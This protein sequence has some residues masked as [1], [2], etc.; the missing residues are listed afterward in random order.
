MAWHEWSFTPKVPVAVRQANARRA[1]AKLVESGQRLHP[2]QLEG[3]KI[4]TTSW[5]K[6][7]CGHLETYS[8]YANRLPRGRSYVRNGS[9]IDL[10]IEAGR[11]RAL[12]SGS[13]IYAVEVVIAQL[14]KARWETLV[15]ECSGKIDSVIE[16]LSGQLSETVMRVLCSPSQGL[17]PS[18]K[19]LALSCSCP[20]HA[21]LCKHLAAVLY[22]V[23]ARLD[24]EPELL[25][26]LR[27][28]EELDL[29]RD[30]ALGGEAGARDLHGDELSNIFGIELEPAP[31]ARPVTS[32]PKPKPKQRAKPATRLAAAQRR[33]DDPLARLHR[34]LTNIRRG[35]RA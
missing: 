23:G 10:H 33:Y 34:A 14:A 18:T 15:G 20:D 22:G 35:K 24:A 19:E 29:V 26:V 16:L 8:D 2:V 28:V 25:F 17:F 27:G 32:K 9:V 6:A 4:A 1:A 7:W 31:S 3:R 5:G 12:V 30:A 13:S 11:V 21:G